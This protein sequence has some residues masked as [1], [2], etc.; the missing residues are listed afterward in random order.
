[1]RVSAN[2][3]SPPVRNDLRF[4]IAFLLL[5]MSSAVAMRVNDSWPSIP[6]RL[7]TSCILMV[8]EQNA[9]VVNPHP[10]SHPPSKGKVPDRFSLPLERTRPAMRSALLAHLDAHLMPR[11]RYRAI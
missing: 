1:M 11:I 4:I 10:E 3:E 6:C 8:E 7:W 5:R 2:I 9:S